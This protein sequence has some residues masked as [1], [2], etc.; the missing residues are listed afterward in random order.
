MLQHSHR[1]DFLFPGQLRSDWAGAPLSLAGITIP[2]GFPE[3][4]DIITPTIREAIEEGYYEASEARFIPR[5]VEPGDRVLELGAG[6]GFISTLVARQPGVEKIVAVEA[7]PKLIPFIRRLHRMNHVDG[8]EVVN[9]ILAN[10]LEGPVQFYL[11]ED[12]WMSSMAPGPEPYCE[13]VEIP[14]VNMDALLRR[15]RIN[16]V[17][18]DVE[19]A[20]ATLFEGADLSSVERF[21]L[22]LHDHLTGIRG[23]ADVFRTLAGQGLIYDPRGSAGPV[24]LFRRLEADEVLR[25]YAGKQ[26]EL[27]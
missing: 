16:L 4:D 13:V 25:P 7:N 24:V 5:I 15:E 2:T 11:R 12:F 14:V 22:E 27:V 26:A 3:T 20:E 21:Y 18:C 1:D 23:I 19:G 6:I 17:I 9:A 8:V 10:G